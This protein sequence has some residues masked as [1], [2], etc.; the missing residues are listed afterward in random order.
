MKAR[1]RY[2]RPSAQA[3][4]DKRWPALRLAAKRR[5]GWRCV[6][7]SR[8]GRLEVDHIRAVRDAPELAFEMSNLQTLCGSCHA[9]KTRLEMG[10]PPPNPE[11]V[12]WMRL[13]DGK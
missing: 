10:F 9:R 2:D 13:I 11:R 6:Q 8:R 1:K 3:Y 7:C 5:D 12:K 4:R